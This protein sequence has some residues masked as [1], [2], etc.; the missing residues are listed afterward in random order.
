LHCHPPVPKTPYLGV[1]ETGSSSQIYLNNGFLVV[2]DPP[3]G[4][5]ILE[6]H[7][8]GRE[9]SYSGSVTAEGLRFMRGGIAEAGILLPGKD[10]KENDCLSISDTETYCRG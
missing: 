6:F 5:L 9:T 7:G 3:Q 1:H 8:K 2:T 10:S 4:G